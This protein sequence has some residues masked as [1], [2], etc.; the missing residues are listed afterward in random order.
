MNAILPFKNS[1]FF[2]E[3]LANSPLLAAT[4]ALNLEFLKGNII[5]QTH[6]GAP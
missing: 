1:S 5:N 3:V 6:S 2:V 4:F